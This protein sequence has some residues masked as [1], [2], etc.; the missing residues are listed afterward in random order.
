MQDTSHQT[1]TPIPHSESVNI[2]ASPTPAS[3]PRRTVDR[4]LTSE[5]APA[6]LQQRAW[7]RAL[8]LIDRFRVIRTIDVAVGIFPER[9]FKAALT[10]AQ[11]AMRRL[12]NADLIR[13]Y[14][15]DRHQHVYGLTAAGARW[16]NDQG[17]EATASVRRVADMTNPEHQLWIGFITLC[18]E[19]RA[20]PAMTESEALREIAAISGGRRNA[21]FLTVRLHEKSRSLRP[22]VLAFETD[23][24][25]WF[26]ID[27][28]KR[29]SDR[30]AALVALVQS[31][32]S[33]LTNGLPLR[34]VVVLARNDRILSRAQG[35]LR[36]RIR[37]T[38]DQPMT[39]ESERRL[40]ETEPGTFVVRALVYADDSQQF[41][42]QTVGH[43]IV[44][45][46]PT[47]LPKFRQT[48]HMVPSTAGWLEENYLP[49]RRPDSMEPWSA[50]ESPL[51]T[52]APE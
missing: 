24:A 21:E 23:G 52:L 38:A 47:W 17:V 40:T 27:R 20:I 45:L 6:L 39:T 51:I 19:A 34:R 7:M 25:T 9:S 31:I 2:P 42:E 46:L 12:S 10:A 49:Y 37:K 16:L 30:E 41:I 5:I 1:S 44:Q 8:S 29:G 35:L 33:G 32:G 11:R 48:R 50:P 3:T 4:G 14:R 18:C 28:S 26:E 15:T 13:R 22:D 43:V 36:D